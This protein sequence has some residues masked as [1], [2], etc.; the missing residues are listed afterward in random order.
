M[1]ET[2]ET[3]WINDKFFSETPDGPVLIGSKCRSC[4]KIQFPQN[5]VCDQC[6]SRSEMDLI[7]LSKEGKLFTYTVLDKTARSRVPYA[8]G[9]VDLPKEKL[10]FFTV[11]SECEPFDTTLKIG[12]DLEVVFEP[13]LTEKDGTVKMG[14][15]FRPKK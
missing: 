1:P 4:G 13:I 14:Y 11:L 2:K 6:F 8:F 10:R 15:K 5:K 9:F 7:P 12:M 3:K